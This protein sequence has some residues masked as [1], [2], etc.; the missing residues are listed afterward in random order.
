MQSPNEALQPE[1]AP[2]PPSE[3]ASARRS[4]FLSGLSGFLSFLLVVA[5]GVIVAAAFGEQRLVAPGPLQ[6]DKVLV[7]APHS[8]VPDI[9]AQLEQGGVIDSPFLVNVALWVEGNRSKVKAGE[10]LFKQNASAQDVMDTLI[11]GRQIL[12]SITIPEGLTTDQILDRLRQSDFLTGDIHETPKEGTL[13]PETYKVPRG[14]ARDA[15]IRKM[16]KDQEDA[17]NRIWSHRAPDNP[18][19]SSFELVTLASIVEKE[20]GKVDERPRVAEV[21]L[22]RLSKHMKL[23]S[24]PTI[25]YGLVGG[26][27]TLGR[28]IL[29]SEVEQPTPYNT[30]VIDGLPPGPIANP[31]VAALEAVANPSRTKELYFVADGTGGH[32]FAETLDQHAK[33]VARWRQIEKDEQAKSPTVDVDHA[34]ASALP[35]T[36]GLP[37]ASPVRG[38]QR[39]SAQ[40]IGDPVFGALPTSFGTPSSALQ[41][42]TGVAPL[43]N[44]ASASAGRSPADA[45]KGP[46]S[47]TMAATP[48]ASGRV[49]PSASSFANFSMG[50]DLDQLGIAIRGVNAPAANGPDL[51]GPIDSA[52]TDPATKAAAA[53]I[54]SETI[55]LKPAMLADERAREAKYGLALQ[56]NVLP[57]DVLSNQ[58]T[59]AKAPAPTT[60]SA[61]PQS[62]SASLNPP[63]HAPV[64]DASEG[65]KLDPLL[66][67]TWDL[68]SPKTV[69]PLTNPP[70]KP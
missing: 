11:S 51:D 15:V 66:D 53:N 59:P 41:A 5:A 45:A 36:T 69:P 27:G 40:T 62:Q 19:K 18:L 32:A 28:G 67:K 63:R 55:P 65:T 33:N 34:P 44:G 47:K 2:P 39:G 12:H 64:Y 60:V 4:P 35:A 43:S 17:V 13:M 61:Q 7:I 31:G 21:F 70:L 22:N 68:N 1:A 20:T 14:M 46:V 9:L 58:P 54:N 3:P 6:A 49:P 56:S 24:D 48:P 42:V 37:P 38:D 50:P 29:K 25:V 8:D 57:A 10:Y 30:Y 26:K 23:Q 16:E 52:A